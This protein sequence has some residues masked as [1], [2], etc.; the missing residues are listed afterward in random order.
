MTVLAA[1]FINSELNNKEKKFLYKNIFIS[2]ILFLFGMI[3]GYILILPYVL[4]FLI[5]YGQEY[6]TPLLSGSIYFSFIGIF[7]FFIGIIFFK[8]VYKGVYTKYSL[9]GFICV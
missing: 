8:S 3:F 5:F 2:S 6:M 1:A 7:C 9:E 4:S